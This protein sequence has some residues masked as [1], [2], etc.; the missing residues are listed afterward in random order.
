MKKVKLLAVCAIAMLM[1][2]SC[3]KKD[4]ENNPFVGKWGVVRIEYYNID[5]AGNPIDASME[6]YDMPLDDPNDGI[7]MIFNANHTGEIIDRA[8]D[9][10]Y[11]LVDSVIQ[12]IPCQDTVLITKISDYNYNEKT[13]VL[14]ITPEH[15]RPYSMVISDLTDNSFTYTNEYAENYVERSYLVRLPSSKSASPA[16]RSSGKRPVRPGALLGGR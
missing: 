7:D 6:V 10:M 2:V 12:F 3:G 9:S 1:L 8:T 11:I 15:A 14:Y 16:K 5:Y 13:S 4:D